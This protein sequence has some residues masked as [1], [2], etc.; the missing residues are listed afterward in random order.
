MK[1]RFESDT[2]KEP[3]ASQYKMSGMSFRRLC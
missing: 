2:Q 1:R 3:L